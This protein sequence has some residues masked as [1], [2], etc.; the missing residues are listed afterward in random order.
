MHPRLILTIFRKDVLDAIR[1]SRVLVAVLV[2]LGIGLFY[3]VTFDDD[4]TQPKATL[5]YASPE[6]TRLPETLREVVGDVTDVTLRQAESAASV[7]RLVEDEDADLGLALPTGFD[8]AVARG[9]APALTVF[10]PASP[11]LG[12]DFLAASLDPALRRLAGQAAPAGVQVAIVAEEE[13]TLAIERLGL[14]RWAVLTSVIFL[15]AMI[16]MLAVPVILAE[17]AERKTLDA[18]TMIASYADV[19]AAKALVGLCYVAL[20]VPLLLGLTR[21]APDDVPGFVGM[22]LAL[23]VTLIGFGL[24]LG[25]LFRS[26]NQLNTWSGVLLLPVLAPVFLVGLSV[27]DLVAAVLLAL[28]TSQATRLAMNALSG[29]ALFPDPALSYL[30]VLA[31]GAAAYALLLWRLSRREG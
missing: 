7:Q 25:G 16:S 1:D 21:L 5:A 6:Q 23:S 29:E 18:L 28:P 9:E 27:P 22:T 4:D 17:E 15:I 30:V 20:A 24:L 10:Q 31:W 14:R 11:S 13:G 3:N 2:P 12:G 26:A 19:T 8:A